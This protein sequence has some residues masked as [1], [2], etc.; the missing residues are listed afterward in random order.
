M[1]VPFCAALA[2]ARGGAT[3]AGLTDFGAGDVLALVPGVSVLADHERARY[4]PRLEARLSNGVLLDWEEAERAD[5]YL[6]SWDSARRMTATL[7]SEVGVAAGASEAL[8]REV[9]RIDTARDLDPLLRALRKA[10]SAIAVPGR[11][12]SRAPRI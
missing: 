2:W 5:A 8:I 3:L 12:S 6:L 1:S 4:S 10:C 9:E 7:A 11:L